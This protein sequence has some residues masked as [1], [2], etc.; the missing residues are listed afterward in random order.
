[1]SFCE[2]C[3][4]QLHE[5]ARFCGGC[6]AVVPDDQVLAPSSAGPAAEPAA[7]TCATCQAEN[8]AEARFCAHCGAAREGATA[9]SAGPDP[10]ASVTVAMVADAAA[11][12]G[13]GAEAG[14]QEAGFRAGMGRA[15]RT[16]WIVALVVAVIVAA[17]AAGVIVKLTSAHPPAPPNP[18]ASQAQDIIAPLGDLARRE[19]V[20]VPSRPKRYK[21]STK[22]SSAVRSGLQLE[23]AATEAKT[24]AAQLAPI[25]AAQVAQKQAIVDLVSALGAYGEAAANLPP[26]L[27]S[28]TQGQALTVHH[29]AV[30]VNEAGVKLH[31][32]ALNLPAIAVRP[33]SGLARGAQMAKRGVA[34]HLFLT[35]VQNGVL[36]QAQYGH[37]DIIR[38]VEGVNSMEM[39]PDVAATLI[40]G[41]QSNRQSLLDQLSAMTVPS[42]SRATKVYSLIQE[43]LQHSIE[44]DRYYAAW[45]HHVYEYY[46]TP[47]VGYQGHVPH[48][49][50]YDSAV[51]QSMMAGSAKSSFCRIYN[52][53]ARLFGLRH[54]WT[55]LEI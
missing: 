13:G 53:L 47:S 48:E 19:S 8:D 29:A 1:M 28:V 26:R 7:W 24:A 40:E 21:W 10:A 17:I 38:A 25:G 54:D 16:T 43:S 37:S 14:A 52:P 39:D 18:F 20:N 35:K 51:S 32:V 11:P 46:Y 23:E 50:N 36:N 34:L 44:A 22:I 4:K 5:G 15:V 33:A 45:M 6:G 42:D 55:P 12:E 30:A 27:A 41:V 9:A 31:A 2:G 49:E 3:G